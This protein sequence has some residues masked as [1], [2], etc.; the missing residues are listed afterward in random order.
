MAKFIGG[1]LDPSVIFMESLVC[2]SYLW[3]SVKTVKKAGYMLVPQEQI[4]FQN[5]RMLY[6]TIEIF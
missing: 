6:T 4:T 5:E 3:N 1:N 2:K